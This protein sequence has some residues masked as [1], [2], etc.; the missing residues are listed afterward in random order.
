MTPVQRE[1]R[2]E[3][4]DVD[5]IEDASHDDMT[6][7]VARLKSKVALRIRS[8]CCSSAA[9]ASRSAARSRDDPGRRDDLEG[10]Q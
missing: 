9:T 5:V 4:F 1:M 3:G 7:A 6:R 8:S 10:S 2:H